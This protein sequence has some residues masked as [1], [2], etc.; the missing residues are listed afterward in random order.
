VPSAQ[1]IDTFIAKLLGHKLIVPV[2]HANGFA[3]PRNGVAPGA[4]CAPELAVYSDMKELLAM[5]PPLPPIESS[6]N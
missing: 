4:W 1:E 6:R 2:D 5:D 3:I